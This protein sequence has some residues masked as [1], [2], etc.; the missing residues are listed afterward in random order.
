MVFVRIFIIDYESGGYGRGVG[1]VLT[2]SSTGELIGLT[3]MRRSRRTGRPGREEIL[4]MNW[5][6]GTE[7]RNW[8]WD[9]DGHGRGQS[10]IP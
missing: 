5:P 10:Q 3:L 4:V 7:E 6:K 1:P 8:F 2:G 9:S